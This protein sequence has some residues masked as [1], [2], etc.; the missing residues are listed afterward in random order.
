MLHDFVLYNIFWSQNFLNFQEMKLRKNAINFLAFLGSSG[1]FGFEVLLDH[2][3]PK[4]TNFLAII[5]QSLI[6]DL[7][8]QA[9]KSAKN[10]GIIHEQ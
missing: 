8:L 1:K 9:S 4:G 2:K 10:S 5:L 7:D 6:Y 3:L